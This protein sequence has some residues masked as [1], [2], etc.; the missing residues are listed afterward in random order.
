MSPY[1]AYESVTR[2]EK[3]SSNEL[4]AVKANCSSSSQIK[5]HTNDDSTSP[6]EKDTVIFVETSEWHCTEKEEE[7]FCVTG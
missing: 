1:I 2:M 3:R 7:N 5:I 4:E 6:D